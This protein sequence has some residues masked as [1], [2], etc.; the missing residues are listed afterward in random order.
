MPGRAND[1]ADLLLQLNCPYGRR[2]QWP[3]PLLAAD[4]IDELEGD[5]VKTI[6][7]ALVFVIFRGRELDTAGDGLFAAFDGPIRAIRCAAAIRDSVRELGLEIRA[8]LHT[9]E[10]EV[11]D[12]KLGGLAVNIGAR[13]AAHAEAGEVLVSSTVKDLVVGSELRFEDRGTA[14]LKGVP[15]PWHLFAVDSVP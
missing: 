6:V 15:G 13:I 7:R 1:A 12:E 8:G 2:M 14:D 11:V 4:L 9:G 10:C 5:G 3:V